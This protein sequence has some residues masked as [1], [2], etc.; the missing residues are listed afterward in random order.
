MTSTVIRS[1]T[2]ITGDGRT[3]LPDTG[4][5]LVDGVV[6]DLPHSDPDRSFGQADLIVDAT[7]KVVTP[8]LI[9]NHTHGTAWGPLFPSAHTALGED[10]VI[11]NLDRHLLEGTT[12]VL[13]VDGF[14]TAE[15]IARTN[16][17]HPNEREADLVPH[18]RLPA[19]SPDRR[20]F[21]APAAFPG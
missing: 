16:Q 11:R 14:M 17:A 13:C 8:G 20:W 3:S 9:N 5:V 1:G 4:V 18:P 6:R 15:E 10:D 2:V 12:T 21:R 19:R 7:G